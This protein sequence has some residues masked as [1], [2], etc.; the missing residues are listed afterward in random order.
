[1]QPKVKALPL[2]VIQLQFSKLLADMEALMN[3]QMPRTH[4]GRC[5]L[6]CTA[7]KLHIVSKG[8][9]NTSQT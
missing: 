8:R 4:A 7:K 3:Q 6:F 1:M 2:V 9:S 5:V